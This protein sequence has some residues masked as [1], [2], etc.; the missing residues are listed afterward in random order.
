MECRDIDWKGIFIDDVSNI[1]SG[2]PDIYLIIDKSIYSFTRNNE[3]LT[4]FERVI[5]VQQRLWRVVDHAAL[6]DDASVVT[7]DAADHQVNTVPFQS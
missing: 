3:L 6:G 2:I 5:S 1:V 4:I 7:D